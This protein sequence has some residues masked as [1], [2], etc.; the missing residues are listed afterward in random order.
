MD[1]FPQELGL[2]AHTAEGVGDVRAAWVRRHGRGLVKDKELV[3]RRQ[4]SALDVNP[5][6]AFGRKRP[7]RGGSLK[8]I[9]GAQAKTVQNGRLFASILF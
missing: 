2:A 8:R 9:W 7:P 4:G 6:R 5:A 1:S 3:T